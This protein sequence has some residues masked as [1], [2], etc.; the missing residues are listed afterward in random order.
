MRCGVAGF[1]TV[2]GG[3][4]VWPSPVLAGM[5]SVQLS[6]WAVL[7]VQ[8]ISF[9]LVIL[10]LAAA[11]VR[12]LWN[13]LAAGFPRLPRLTYRR[14]WRQSSCGACSWAWC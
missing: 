13:L 12:W 4:L 2:V 9:F 3:W 1:L 11:V 5:P 6:D 10:L 14:A 8:T 7:R